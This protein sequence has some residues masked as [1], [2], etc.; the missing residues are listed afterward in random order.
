[1]GVERFHGE[2]FHVEI[3]PATPVHARELA[4]RLRPRDLAEVEASGVDPEEDLLRGVEVSE[5]ART[6]LVAGRVAA[7]WGVIRL[8]LLNPTGCVWFL[9]S[10]D[11]ERVPVRLMRQARIEIAEM[12]AVFPV[13]ATMMHARHDQARRFVERIGFEVLPAVAVPVTGELFHPIRRAA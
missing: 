6:A 1:M 5:W 12:Q 4:A 7:M 9:T 13:L 11:V 8:G 10:P 2:P 3:L